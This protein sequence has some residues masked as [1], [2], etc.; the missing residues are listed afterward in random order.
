[1]AE[2]TPVNQKNPT[3]PSRYQR[4]R[5][6]LDR[7]AAGSTFQLSRLWSILAAALRRF[8]R[9]LALR[10]PDDCP[11]GRP[12]EGA[13]P[14]PLTAQSGRASR[15]GVD[16]RMGGGGG[17]SSAVAAAVPVFARGPPRQA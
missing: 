4:V 6:I 1:M 10:R 17:A 5:D 2:E 8:P 3:Q 7:A 11:G 14:S 9:V 12:P 15:D 16:R 13:I